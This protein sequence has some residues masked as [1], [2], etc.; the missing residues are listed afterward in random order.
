MSFK[1]KILARLKEKFTGLSN[2][3][4]LEHVAGKLESKVTADEQIDGQ[5][6]ALNAILPISEAA[7]FFD[8]QADKR[9]SDA[10][11][12]WEAKNKKPEEAP[13]PTPAPAPA[14]DDMPAWAKAM[15][16]QNDELKAML[17]AVTGA[18][19]AKNHNERMTKLFTEK[20]VDPMFYAHAVDGRSFKD[21]AECDA[22][23]NGIVESWGKFAQ[24]QA[25]DGMKNGPP[26]VFGTPPA[27]NT[28]VSPLVKQMI[29]DAAPKPAAAV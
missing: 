22:F 9:V 20:K 17:T 12:A 16:T 29:A 23:A 8:S 13:T 25:D 27:S 2:D 10:Q 6:D 24:K 11:K 18:Q 26:P 15:Q 1:A 4:Y 21:D 28:E 19:V 3:A 7:K 14:P 5:I